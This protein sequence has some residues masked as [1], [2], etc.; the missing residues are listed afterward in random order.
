M[1][2][3]NKEDIAK[4]SLLKDTIKWNKPLWLKEMC[5]KSLARVKELKFPSIKNDDW[6]FT[7]LSPLFKYEFYPASVGNDLSGNVST[8]SDTSLTLADIEKYL[9]PATVRLVFV[10]GQY[11]PHLSDITLAKNTLK[12]SSLDDL[13]N[14]VEQN[15]DEQMPENF[16]SGAANDI[17]GELNGSFFADGL[18][19]NVASS[20]KDYLVDNKTVLDNA[21]KDTGVV[22][23]FLNIAVSGN[24]A[25]VVYP[26]CLMFMGI[27]SQA[28]LI[29]DYV[30]LNAGKMDNACLSNT[31]TEIVLEENA[32]LQHVI[33]Q[34]KDKRD[35]YIGNCKV[36]LKKNSIYTAIPLLLGASLSRYMV[37]TTL[38]GCGAT[39]D[40][41]GLTLIDGQQVSDINTVIRHA[42]PNTNSIQLHKCLTDERSHAIFSGKI[43]V[44]KASSGTVSEQQSRNLILSSKSRINTTPQLEIN[45]DDVSCSHG[46]TVSQMDTETLFF[47]KSRGISEMEAKKLFIHAFTADIINKIKV[48]GLIEL[49]NKIIYSA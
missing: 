30:S 33:L 23:H 26:R 8:K 35:F 2:V 39:A 37:N 27:N 44:D 47:L 24:V 38:L 11:V 42:V 32:K 43:I 16:A 5:E 3:A 29:E 31:M 20:T 34:R 19:V 10:D 49:L 13:Y 36:G 15:P 40:L 17:F 22:I 9:I 12:I 1:N 28:T 18:A 4:E 14:S 48:A 21:E 6:R 25:K 41:S 46:A 7:D 45:N